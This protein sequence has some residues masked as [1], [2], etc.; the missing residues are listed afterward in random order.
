MGSEGLGAKLADL[1]ST[2][3]PEPSAELLAA[4]EGR[5][6]AERG[7]IAWLRSRPTGTRI[8]LGLGLAIAL[9]AFNLVGSPRPD[10]AVYPVVRMVVEVGL[11]AALIGYA[12][13][14][15]LP[16]LQSRLT[17]AQTRLVLVGV[18]AIVPIVAAFLPAAHDAHPSIWEGAGDDFVPRAVACFGY[19]MAMGLPVL[20]V[21]RFLERGEHRAW[22]GAALAATAG[23]LVAQL[24]LH[25]H[26]A[27]AYP[28]HLIAGHVT[29]TVVMLAAYIGLSRLI[30]SR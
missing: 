21:L 19:G 17:P 26:C 22:I 18:A 13:R 23:G 29:V 24:S 15:S 3:G 5:I 25:L 6:E 27:I 2:T 28:P 1:A 12:V 8:G 10:L 7:P 4:V 14:L 20:V 16:E 11:F 9:V 30:P